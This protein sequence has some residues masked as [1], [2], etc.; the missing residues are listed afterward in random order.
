[1]P[2]PIFNR[3]DDPTRFVRFAVISVNPGA[4]NSKSCLVTFTTFSIMLWAPG[5][6]MGHIFFEGFI[7]HEF[8]YNYLDHV[9]FTKYIFHTLH[10]I[11]S[12]GMAT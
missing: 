7:F 9:Q 4:H 3:T 8:Q 12:C 2:N 1:M 6:H 11:Q 10:V 5:Y